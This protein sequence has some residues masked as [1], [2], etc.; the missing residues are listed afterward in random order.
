MLPLLV[1][2]C[3][4]FRSGGSCNNEASS[5]GGQFG[6]TKEDCLDEAW[7]RGGREWEGE[8]GLGGTQAGSEL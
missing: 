4:I 1:A 7:G 3:I 8:R 2:G 6:F 5:K